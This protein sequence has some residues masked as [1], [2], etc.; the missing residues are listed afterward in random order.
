MGSRSFFV[1]VIALDVEGGVGSL[2]VDAAG[3]TFRCIDVAWGC[4]GA[5]WVD[6][7]VG[8]GGGESEV[9]GGAGA[10]SGVERGVSAV[11]CG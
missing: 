9:A 3:S 2:V 4:G 5:L 7:L 11:A 1:D 6:F 8:G 10:V